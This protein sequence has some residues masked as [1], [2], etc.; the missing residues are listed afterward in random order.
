MQP[1]QIVGYGDY[2]LTR[3]IATGGMAEVFRA[4]K[5]GEAG[6]EKL[7]VV[8][9]LLPHLAADQ[10]LLDMFLDEA[11]LASQLSNQNIVQVYD[12]G[13]AQENHPSKPRSEATYFIGME[14][15]FGKSL[16]ETIK[17]SLELN[18]PLP[19]EDTVKVI[20]G[21]AL[22][23]DYAHGKSGPDGRALSLVHRDISPQNILVSYDGEVKLAD[24]G[25]AKALSQSQATRPGVLKGK[26]AYMSPEQAKGEP[27]DAR[28]DLYSL[29]IVFWE[30]LCAQR[31][32][33]AGNEA[34]TLTKVTNPQVE[35][36]SKTCSL[37]P[38]ALDKVVLKLL[39]PDP[40]SR[41]QNARELASD[42]EEYLHS[43]G[44]FPS[45]HTLHEYMHSLFEPEIQ[46]ETDQI[47]EEI[48]AIRKLL[49]S[50]PDADE[51]ADQEP[52]VFQ[53]QP[54]KKSKGLIMGV[55]ALVVVLAAGGLFL[56]LSDKEED[57]APHAKATA[58]QAK[59]ESA[60]PTANHKA[61]AL[62][63]PAAQPAKAPEQAQSP[64]AKEAKPA[65][66]KAPPKAVE[67]KKPEQKAA[68]QP[69]Q[70]PVETKAK[71]EKPK[72]EQAAQPAAAPAF[73]VPAPLPPQVAEGR[74]ALAEG[75]NTKALELFDQALE[76]DPSLAPRLG[77]DRAGA[78]L[79][80]ASGR[81]GKEPDQA[82]ADAALATQLA[83]DWARG[84]LQAGRI[85]T[86]LS[87]MD[88]ALA[89]Y[90]KAVALDPGLAA[91]HFNRG[92]VFLSRKD[93]PKAVEAFARVVELNSPFT[94]DALVNLAV[95]RHRMGDDAAAIKDLKQ[96]L[97]VNPN[98]ALAIKYL[99]R[100]QKNNKKP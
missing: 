66:E 85:Q 91:A 83:P 68:P 51:P 10:E 50:P 46:K 27:V 53:A 61:P 87:R 48:E 32:F 22:G 65:A 12:L 98:H 59:T 75:R 71:A 81:L 26:F 95:C 47:R 17:R 35:P 84:Y 44:A 19:V 93:Y 82:L 86:R 37:V 92:Y 28:S 78:L 56:A 33:A 99:E 15:V 67:A 9:R 94:A 88:E 8:K 60:K 89:S 100:L 52:T 55:A 5:V 90:D 62:P 38:E 54:G 18:R 70:K 80:R 72:P 25:I 34:A 30:T 96:A 2:Y 7:L 16:S 77:R 36:P 57:K 43:V 74:E 42:L 64:A 49:D 31:L 69:A 14:Y 24:F 1:W 58:P 45:A 4:R 63:K 29:G 6:F 23:L 97:K 11:R 41:Y 21:A 73:P 79:G 3:K 76:Q 13:K 40:D 39:A 20:L